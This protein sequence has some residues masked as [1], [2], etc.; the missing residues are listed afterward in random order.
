M[1]N[2]PHHASMS[3]L[4]SQ[5]SQGTPGGEEQSAVREGPGRAPQG[6]AG[7]ADSGE[8][9]S[10][11]GKGDNTK[12]HISS[13]T[14]PLDMLLP[15][16]L[17]ACLPPNVTQGGQKSHPVSP[18]TQDTPRAP[19]GRAHLEAAGVPVVPGTF[20]LFLLLC[21]GKTE[22]KSLQGSWRKQLPSWQCP[23]HSPA[24]VA[25]LWSALSAAHTARP[26]RSWEQPFHHVPKATLGLGTPTL[27]LQG[28]QPLL[29]LVVQLLQVWGPRAG[30]EDV[31]GTFLAR[32]VLHA[33][34]LLTLALGSACGDSGVSQAGGTRPRCHQCVPT[35]R[36]RVLGGDRHLRMMLS[37]PGA[38]NTERNPTRSIFQSQDVSNGFLPITRAVLGC[39]TTLLPQVNRV[40]LGT[41]EQGRAAQE[42]IKCGWNKD[43]FPFPS[44][45]CVIPRPC[46]SP[47]EWTLPPCPAMHRRGKLRHIHQQRSQRTQIPAPN[48]AGC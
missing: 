12:G 38:G 18:H 27:V 30:E 8:N 19:W 22:G 28:L 15:P 33:Q 32:R 13:P 14:T 1:A 17:V 43:Y 20:G 36:E 29:G 10:P 3:A 45:H 2:S 39:G 16:W 21:G 23:L 37:K 31:V 34:P 4:I 11:C 46:S 24:T 35:H 6:R 26:A 47:Q 5:G 44:E 25:G 7:R 40:G 41:A 42:G 9:S 48:A